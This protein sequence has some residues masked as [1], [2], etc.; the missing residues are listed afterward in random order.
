MGLA[1]S[2]NA[3]LITSFTNLDFDLGV[4]NVASGFDNPSSDVPGWRNNT[5]MTDSGVEGPGAWWGPYDQY[6]AWMKTGEAAYN[7]SDYT[8]QAGDVFSVSLMAQWWQWT[9]AKGQWTATLFYDN[10]ANVIG[11]YVTPDLNPQGSWTA[12]TSTPIAATAGSVGGKLGILMAS[13]GGGIA[14]VDEISVQV[15]PE[16]SSLALAGLALLTS[17]VARQ[18]MKA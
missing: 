15:V 5:A 14:Q 4:A 6:A 2:A 13:T 12:Y 3:Q 18:K 8:I 17:T 9:G 7:T 10:P 16:P 11:S 1:A